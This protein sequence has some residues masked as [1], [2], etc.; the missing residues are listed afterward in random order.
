MFYEQKPVEMKLLKYSGYLGAVGAL[1]REDSGQDFDDLM[2]RIKDHW[3][4]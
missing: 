3:K 1:I 4:S 2:E